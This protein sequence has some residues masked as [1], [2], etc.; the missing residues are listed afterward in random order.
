MGARKPFTL[1]K[2]GAVWYC[3]FRELD[4]GRATAKSTGETAKA[5]AEQWAVNYLRKGQGRIA[6]SES[7]TLEH[8]ATDF[9]SWSG[10]WATDKRARGLR[11]SENHCI[12]RREL[13]HNR[14]LPVLGKMR[15]SSI[16]KAA[17][18]DFRN[19]LFRDGYSGSTINKCL[20]AL[21][22]ILDAAEEHGLIQYVPKIERAAENPKQKGILTPDEVRRLFSFQWM[23]RPARNH[24]AKPLDVEQAG[25]LLAAVTGVRLSEVQGLM[26]RDVNFQ[27]KYITVRRA[28]DNRMLRLN[29]TT[30]SGRERVI[31]FPDIVKN[32]LLHI[33]G[34]NPFRDH[35]DAFLFFGDTEDMPK[36]KRAFS[37][38]L[39]R[40]LEEIGITAEEQKARNVTFHS[41]RHFL[42]S[43][44][45]NSRIPLQKI[46]SIVGH[47][48]VEM[49]TLYYRPDD[50]TDV[51]QITEGIFH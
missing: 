20:S 42:N 6:K 25:N 18:K 45:V 40:A 38:S 51:L 13:L 14:I 9:F 48:S 11:L 22:A 47:S 4:G 15:L 49:T 39:S 34:L 1:F 35:P 44:L 12:Q 21:K 37:V 26:L 7:I 19:G 32:S 43:L 23:S 28:W 31:F 29:Q 33:T 41:H 3:Q 50:M 8:F 5:R 36:D 10:S 46:Q 24:P 2:R 17:I 16:N 30:K 27:D